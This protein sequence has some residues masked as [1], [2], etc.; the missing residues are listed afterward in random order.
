MTPKLTISFLLVALAV[1]L[2]LY[3]WTPPPGSQTAFAWIYSEV[4]IDEALLLLSVTVLLIPLVNRHFDSLLRHEVRLTRPVMVL[5][6]LALV[7]GLLLF[8]FWAMVDL[9]G[10]YGGPGYT[11]STYPFIAAIYNGIGLSRL[12]FPNR[13][14]VVGFLS[15][16]VAVSSFMALRARRGIGIAVRDGVA[17]FA[18]PILV[19]FEL[20]LWYN[21]P[22]DMYWHVTKFTSWSLGVYPGAAGYFVWTGNV[23]LLSNWSVLIVSSILILIS[24]FHHLNSYMT[25]RTQ[26]VT[27]QGEATVPQTVQ[28]NP[29]RA[30][31]LLSS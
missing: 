21:A 26:P 16:C 13:Q 20:A 22:L 30:G 4:L 11:W 8:A 5:A 29:P 1:A 6:V 18:A 23:Y 10:G 3:V 31:S 17:F 27:I 14:G 12:P 25:R 24:V 28:A 2:L 15:F 9:L 7:L 19:V